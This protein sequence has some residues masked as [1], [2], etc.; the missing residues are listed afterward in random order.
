[1]IALLIDTTN[2]KEVTVGLKIDGKEFINKKPLDTRKAQVVLP[3][4]EKMLKERGLQLKD[5]NAIEV[6][7]GPGSFTGIRV[8]LSIA[9]TLGFLLKI[10][11]NGKRVGLTTKAVYQ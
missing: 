6:N 9:N 1:M 5:L 8:G 2:N 11:V 10:P 7:P 4:L 3:I